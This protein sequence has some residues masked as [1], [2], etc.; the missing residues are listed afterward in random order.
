MTL[1]E[2]QA[3]I[4]KI[5][6]NMSEEASA[7]ASEDFLSIISTYK[8]VLDEIAG[9]KEE[10]EKVKATNEELLITNGRLFQKIGFEEEKVE[11]AVEEADEEEVDIEDIIDEKGDII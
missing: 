1:E 6:G 7:L 5:K 8:T 3:L 2:L 4:D 10:M 9:L 11:E